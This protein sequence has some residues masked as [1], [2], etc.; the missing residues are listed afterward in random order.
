MLSSTVARAGACLQVDAVQVTELC[1][2]K[3]ARI[4]VKRSQ[5]TARS[6]LIW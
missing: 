1:L 2:E 5:K 3:N 4:H 6:D